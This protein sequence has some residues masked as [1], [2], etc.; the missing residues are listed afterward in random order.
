MTGG[1]VRSFW[2][3]VGYGW[4]FGVDWGGIGGQLGRPKECFWLVGCAYACKYVVVVTWCGGVWG[5]LVSMSG[6][7]F[8]GRRGVGAHSDARRGAL[9]C[10]VVH[11]A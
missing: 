2:S 6:G 4:L 5:G 9:K 3:C 10:T 7:G 1:S 11:I 8:G